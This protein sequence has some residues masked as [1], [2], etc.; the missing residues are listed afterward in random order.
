MNIS[1][2]HD[3]IPWDLGRKSDWASL[4]EDEESLRYWVALE[5]RPQGGD[6]SSLPKDLQRT[7]TENVMETL[8]LWQFQWI[9]EK[10]ARGSSR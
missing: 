2:H 4:S 6:T 7:P 3:G 8:H 1:V 10:R 5:I 9:L